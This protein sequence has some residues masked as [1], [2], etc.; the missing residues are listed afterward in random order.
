MAAS[1][2]FM[3]KRREAVAGN[4]C[5]AGVGAESS[6]VRAS[7]HEFIPVK[8]F[9]LAATL[10]SGQVFHWH[11]KGDVFFGLVHDQIVA[12]AQPQNNTLRVHAGDAAAARHYFALDHDLDAIRTTLPPDDRHLNAALEHALGLRILRQPP[13]ECLATFITSSL[14]QVA[15]IRQISLKLRQRFGRHV[16]VIE[17]VDLFAYPEPEALARAGEGALRECGLGY[18]AKFLHQCATRIAEGSFDVQ[19]VA[20]LDDE[21]AQARLCEL[22]GVGPKIAQCT[23]LFGYGRLGMFPVDVWIERVLRSLYFA[24]SRRPPKALRL[25]NF[26]RD[27][28]GP[29]RGYAQQWLFHHA[30]TGEVFRRGGKPIDSRP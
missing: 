3:V 13:W 11:R 10:D 16:G 28:F 19:A 8:D 26:V 27:H 14:K 6:I 20:A 15:H 2:D 5:S 9:D 4:L 29:Y 12:L 21:A 22:P 23:L 7:H 17:G 24:K 25:K 1:S 18:R 30:R